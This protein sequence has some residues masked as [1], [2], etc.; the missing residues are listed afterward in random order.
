MGLVRK[1]LCFKRLVLI[2]RAIKQTRLISMYTVCQ[3]LV[4]P[5]SQP[6][7]CSSSK[8]SLMT[9]GVLRWRRSNI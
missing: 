8:H 1:I 3:R 2:S 9:M 5:R 7:S 4:L 6:S